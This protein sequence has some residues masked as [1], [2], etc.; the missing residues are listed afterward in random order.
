MRRLALVLL[1]VAAALVTAVARRSPAGAGWPDN[2]DKAS[3]KFSHAFHVG[4][5]GVACLDCHKGASTS[6][7]S[8][9][10]LRPAH[11]NCA[12]C[13]EDQVNKQCGFCHLDTLN[14]Q[15]AVRPV[16]TIVFSHAKHTAMKDVEC[17]TCHPG[18]DKTEYAGPANMPAMATCITCHDNARAT[19]T[20][21]SCHASFVNLV[22][23][24]HLVAD[25]RKDHK[26][27][28]R[29]GGL[30]VSCATCH[31]QNFCADCHGAAPLERF[32][33]S[34]LMSEPSPRSSSTSNGPKQMTLQMTHNM[35]YRYTHGIDAKAKST[36]CF[37]C[38]NART[39]C[40]QC[41]AVGD[42]LTPGAKP[43]SHLS[44][45][46]TTLG[47]GSGG[48]KHA[49]LALRDIESCMSCHDAR[50]ADPVCITCHV[51]P[52]GIKGTHPRTHPGGFMQNEG[53][54]SWHR[55]PGATCFNCHTD[56]NAS[57]GGV[58]G[59]GFCGYCH[60]PK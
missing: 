59:R 37:D 36:E 32:G 30:D 40:E 39:F 48:G 29:L 2:N 47:R 28:T 24:D 53:N 18:L 15:A 35:N 55:D 26:K 56:M 52:D 51:D 27:M 8:S 34:A 19:G 1:V 5:A 23:A 44:P 20:C 21:E 49:E 14:I 13:H 10:N 46:F 58:A 3:L 6:A 33:K 22:P 42:N 12:T 45:G 57:P 17:A 9:D 43:A 41:H 16:R 7:S 54:G 4:E 31:T 38:H 25:F 11:E 50:G 60:G